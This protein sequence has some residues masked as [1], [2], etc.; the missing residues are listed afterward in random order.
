MLLEAEDVDLLRKI[1]RICDSLETKRYQQENLLA[2]L[3][4]GAMAGMANNV[5][6]GACG[7]GSKI[8]R[9][10][11]MMLEKAVVWP[12]ESQAHIPIHSRLR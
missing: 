8:L 9:I 1:E 10:T 2:D 12:G 5:N 6:L 3:G 4:N 7:Y 11:G